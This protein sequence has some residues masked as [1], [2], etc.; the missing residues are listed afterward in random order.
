[1]LH[2]VSVLH[3]TGLQYR[4]LAAVDV[5]GFDEGVWLIH[6]FWFK[7]EDCEVEAADETE[8]LHHYLV[9]H[10]ARRLLFA[11]PEIVVLEPAEVADPR[12]FHEETLR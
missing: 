6:S 12:T 1:M 9:Y 4:A 8:Y 5:F 3:V 2:P 7:D 10:A 11:L